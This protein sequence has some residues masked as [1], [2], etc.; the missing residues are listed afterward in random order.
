MVLERHLLKDSDNIHYADASIPFASTAVFSFSSTYAMLDEKLL[1][2]LQYYLRTGEAFDSA[3][4]AIEDGT[5]GIIRQ[6]AVI[7]NEEVTNSAS[8]S[9][10]QTYNA[11]SYHDLEALYPTADFSQDYT[12]AIVG[13]L[14]SFV[15]SSSKPELII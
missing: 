1:A 2:Q 13:L 9:P 5:V 3:R 7:S 8:L 14:C 10:I 15:V 4:A 12:A 6:P 11:D